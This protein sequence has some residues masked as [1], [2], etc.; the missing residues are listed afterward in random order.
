MKKCNHIYILFSL[1]LFINLIS[2]FQSAFLLF[3]PMKHLSIDVFKVDN[4]AAL[5]QR[6]HLFPSRTQK[7]SSASPE[8]PLGGDMEAAGFLLLP[9]FYRVSTMFT[10][11]F[12]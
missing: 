4:P 2:G 1:D 5:A 7:L 12:G 10:V 8:V 9:F 11:R 3:L 6:Y